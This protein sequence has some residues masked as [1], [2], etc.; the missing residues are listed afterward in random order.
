MKPRIAL[1]HATP[2]AVGPIHAAFARDWPDAD[3]IDIMDYSLSPDRAQAGEITKALSDRILALAQYGVSTGAQAVLF[4]CSAFGSAIDHAAAQI[5]IPVLKPN[6][7]MFQAAMQAGDRIAMIYT[8]PPAA[9]SMEQEFRDEVARTGSNATLTSI[10]A[11]GAIEAAR[12]GDI[13]THDRLV[14]QVAK[15]LTGFDAITLAHFSTSTALAS[16]RAVNA[17]PT[18]ASPPAAIAKL[19]SLLCDMPVAV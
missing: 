16:V 7:A 2:I 4:T 12:A 9:A 19:K 3:A 11:P 17:T 8:F 6:E 1:I 14:S 15:G 10:L 13:A 18:Y 5:A